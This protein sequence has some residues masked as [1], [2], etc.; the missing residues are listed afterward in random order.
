M[1]TPA[2]IVTVLQIVYI[3]QHSGQR[4]WS[5]VPAPSEGSVRQNIETA[6]VSRTPRHKPCSTAASGSA[7][8]AC[9]FL[10]EVCL[11]SSK[12]NRRNLIENLWG[13][14]AAAAA[15]AGRRLDVAGGEESVQLV[16]VGDVQVSADTAEVGNLPGGARQRQL[17]GRILRRGGR[18]CGGTGAEVAAEHGAPAARHSHGS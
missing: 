3:Y 5:A 11:L 17:A 6:I 13:G 14:V 16:T 18:T 7:G 10:V 15:A 12:Y 8:S 9:A 4:T 1:E 2:V